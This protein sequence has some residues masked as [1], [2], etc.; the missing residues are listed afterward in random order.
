M[1]RGSRFQN[2]VWW[3]VAG[4]VGL[5]L[6][7]HFLAYFRNP[8]VLGGAILLE[9]LL[10]SLWHYEV[11]YF[12]L[13]ISFF[14][15]S[16]TAIPGAYVAMSARWPALAV[17]AIGGAILWMRGTRHSFGALHL[18]AL[19]AALAALAS[20]IVSTDQMGSLM[21]VVSLFLLFVYCATG[22]RLA[23]AGREARF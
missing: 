6:A 16:G 7:H 19:F 15:W 13:L 23:M 14:V 1:M 9:I 18:A 20:A 2:G 17:G 10:A 21:K 22:A 4:I 3:T 8:V 5:G 11:V 12:P